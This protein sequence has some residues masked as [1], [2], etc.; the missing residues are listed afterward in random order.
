MDVKAMQTLETVPAKTHRVKPDTIAK[1]VSTF[2]RKAKGEE[3][4]ADS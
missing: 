1:S 3:P 4:E 2:E